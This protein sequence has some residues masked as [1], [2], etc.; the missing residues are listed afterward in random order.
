MRFALANT[1][2][3]AGALLLVL[4]AGGAAQADDIFGG[5]SAHAIFEAHGREDDS[6]DALIGYRTNP[7]QALSLIWKPEIHAIIAV[8]DKYSTDF[9]AVGLDWR[10]RLSR[11]FYFRPGI[12]LA[13]TT[14]KSSLPAVNAP[15]LTQA[16]ITAR[17][18]EYLERI[19]FGDHVLFEPELAVGYVFTPQ[20]SV[21]AS[22]IHLSNGQILHQGRNEGLD[23]AGL[24]L[25]YHFH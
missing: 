25:S 18:N 1:L 10:I 2:A 17:T 23:D 13:Y 21:E 9:A 20:W 6:F 5:L 12:G 11:H 4:A 7:I 22:Y 14:G 3:G 19:D 24:R 16:E 15:G 8:N